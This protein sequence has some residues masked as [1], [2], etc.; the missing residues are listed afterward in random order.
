MSGSFPSSSL[1]F[2]FVYAWSVAAECTFRGGF[3]HY[4][5]IRRASFAPAL[6]GAQKTQSAAR[7]IK[8][9]LL[10]LSQTTVRVFDRTVIVCHRTRRLKPRS[11]RGQLSFV[12]AGQRKS[13]I[14]L[15]LNQTRLLICIRKIN[16]GQQTST[17]PDSK[18]DALQGYPNAVG[19]VCF[20]A[21]GDSLNA[22]SKKKPTV[23][24]RKSWW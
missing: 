22:K 6:S 16:T 2:C 5:N 23:T 14:F 9:I 18:T 15:I 11:F 10:T 3:I 13:Y 8:L 12:C 20:S 19:D 4:C 17:D 7:F 21:D 1:L 24:K